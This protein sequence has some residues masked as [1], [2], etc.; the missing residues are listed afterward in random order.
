MFSLNSSGTISQ[1]NAKGVPEKLVGLFPPTNAL[2]Y[3][4]NLS[5][6][7]TVYETRHRGSRANSIV[8]F[9]KLSLKTHCA[10]IRRPNTSRSFHTDASPTFLCTIFSPKNRTNFHMS[11][12]PRLPS[13][14]LKWLFSGRIKS[15]L[16]GTLP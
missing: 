13:I 10:F 2:H 16:I 14:R 8:S 9:R 4:Y 1:Q 15:R 12:R 7:Q 11:L 5:A 6:E 3:V